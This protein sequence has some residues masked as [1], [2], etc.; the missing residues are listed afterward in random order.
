MMI[1]IMTGGCASVPESIIRQPDV[2]LS[3]VECTSLGLNSQTFVLS[4]DV[5]NPNSFALPVAAVSYGLK[6]EGKRFATGETSGRFTVPAKGSREF[7]INVDLNLLS[8]A[9]E[10]LATIRDGVRDGIG[11]ELKGQF[12]L[13]LPAIG[14]VKYRKAG[15]VQLHGSE[16]SFLFH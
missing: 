16:A 8:T 7:A 10:L 12:D 11:Y 13:D 9:P 3:R 6:L 5:H 15:L 1:L 2:S 14:A 4:F